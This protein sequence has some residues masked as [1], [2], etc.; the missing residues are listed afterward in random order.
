[1]VFTPSTAE[2]AA[3]RK[4]VSA[5]VN[6]AIT[7]W[8][9]WGLTYLSILVVGLVVYAAYKLN[10]IHAWSL[11][12][13]LITAYAAFVAG[14]FIN[15][16][17]IRL[18]YRRLTRAFHKGED[19]IEWELSFDD[20]AMIW[21][22]EA[23]ESRVSWRAIRAIEDTGAMLLLWRDIPSRTALIPARVFESAEARA[24]FVAAVAAQIT[25]ARRQI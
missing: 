25:A 17:V 23:V 1:L 13:V 6:R 18:Q 12:P 4:L 11:K 10:L 5:R 8:G 9:Y 7:G 15:A 2:L 19:E 20:T 16:L 14:G 3:A 24:A 22:C 21:R